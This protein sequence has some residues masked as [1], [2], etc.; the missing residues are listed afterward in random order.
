MRSGQ[1]ERHSKALLDHAKKKKHRLT[2]NVYRKNFRAVKFYER[3]GFRVCDAG[4]D[5]ATGEED[6]SMEWRE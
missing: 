2:L 3:E 1:V 5:D 4:S 6:L